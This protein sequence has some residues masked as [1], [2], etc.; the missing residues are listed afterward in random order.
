M[1]RHELEQEGNWRGEQLAKQTSKW[2][3]Q[4]LAGL[5]ALG[6]ANPVQAHQRLLRRP[7]LRRDSRR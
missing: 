3:I 1:H 4:N 5:K 7:E 2:N 6:I